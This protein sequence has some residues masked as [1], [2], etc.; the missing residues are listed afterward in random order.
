MENKFIREDFFSSISEYEEQRAAKIAEKLI[1][2]P[3]LS[4]MMILFPLLFLTFVTQMKRYKARREIFRD[5]YLF[6]RKL[7]LEALRTVENREQIEEYFRKNIYKECEIEN[8]DRL[9][10]AQC[11]EALELYKKYEKLITDIEGEKNFISE[12]VREAE[13]NTLL[14]SR[15]IFQLDLESLALN[16]KLEKILKEL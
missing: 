16:C 13:L 5:E 4:I 6:T 10:E 11:R 1:E 2:K 8:I 14:I 9:F 7:A 15:E 12:E 3:Q